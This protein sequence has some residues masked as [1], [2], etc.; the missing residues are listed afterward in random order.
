MKK[1]ISGALLLAI[2]F[3]ISSCSQDKKAELEKIEKQISELEIKADQLRKELADANLNDSTSKSDGLILPVGIDTLQKAAFYHKV[4]VQ[5]TVQ[6]DENITITAEVMSPVTQILV[7]E[8]DNV[9]KGQTIIK[10]DAAI[11]ENSIAE[12][13]NRLELAEITFE[14]QA[15]LWEK[16]VGTEMQ[17]LQAKNQRDALRKQLS[18]LQAQLDKYIIKSPING[19]IDD[20]SVNIGENVSPGFRMIRVVNLSEV[21]IKAEVPESYVGKIKKGDSVSIKFP[22]ISYIHFAKVTNVGQVISSG[23]RTFTVQVKFKNPDNKLKPN[24]LALLSFVD[25]YNPSVISIPSSIIISQQNQKI[26]SIA[27]KNSKGD[28]EVSSKTVVTG[29]TNNGITEILEGLN[30]GDLLITEGYKSLE[31][32][33]LLKIVK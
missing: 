26:V 25:Y 15:K 16:K 27:V 19:V 10:L 32:G 33:D 14:K 5:G 12:V 18:T 9:S 6:S 29:Q 31:N 30:E 28:Y 24:L 17:Y 7:K 22:A 1:S 13:R 21:E 11:T 4:E 20:I 23:N 3:V 8:G 2:L